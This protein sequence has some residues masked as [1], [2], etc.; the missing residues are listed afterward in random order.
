MHRV[1]RGPKSSGH[2]GKKGRPLLDRLAD[3]ETSL[4]LSYQSI[5]GAVAVRA[6]I[7]PAAEWLIDNFYQVERQVREIRT[8][9]PPGYFRQL[10]KLAEGPFARYP[11]V[12]EIARAYV[13][14]TDSR[15]DV[16]SWCSFLRAY[17]E[18]QY[19]TIGE[20]WVSA[21]TLRHVLIE[22]LRRIADRVV[23]SRQLNP[24]NHARTR[25]ELRRYK[26]EPYVIAA[27]VYAASNH[28]GY[29]GW[30]WYTGSAGWM[31]RAGLE[32]IL[33]LQCEGS[34]LH[35]DPC[36]PNSWPG[37]EIRLRRRSAQ[38]HIKIENPKGVTR[39]VAAVRMDG[40]LLTQRPLRFELADDC[41]THEL[42]ITSG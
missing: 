29:G 34:S 36:I 14:H 20:L 10:L 18:V 3:N 21:I 41:L 4:L 30:T 1:W 11:R 32:S 27:D 40:T 35:I 16:D 5:C 23:Y 6:A 13:A 15:F 25:A 24:I 2:I 22:N 8:E 42:S 28:V 37:F 31:Q 12:F 38:L 7:S 39:G 26:V 19:L 33:G 17:Q 9:L